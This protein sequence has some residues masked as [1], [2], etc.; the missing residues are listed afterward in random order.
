MN[1]GDARS[2]QGHFTVLSFSKG[3][4]SL[5]PGR[6]YNE[7]KELSQTFWGLLNTSSTLMLT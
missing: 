6:L 4:C 3:T 2:Y 7:E 1:K 5:L